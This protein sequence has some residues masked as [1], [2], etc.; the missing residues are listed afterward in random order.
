[1]HL[2]DSR[3]TPNTAE[4]AAEVLD[5][6]AVLINLSSGVYYSL[7]GAG[8]FVW[9]CLENGQNCGEIIE[10]LVAQFAVSR[11]TAQADLGALLDEF[12][13]EKLVSPGTQ[14]PSQ[15]VEILPA[16]LPYETPSLKIYSDMQELLALDPPMPDL[17]DAPYRKAS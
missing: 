11:E 10:L 8:S 2:P 7:A 17:T 1:M 6:E 15:S 3:F 13:R 4:I 16:R 12:L 5:G 9:T 14:A